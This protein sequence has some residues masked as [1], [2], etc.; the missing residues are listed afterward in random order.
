[1]IIKRHFGILTLGLVLFSLIITI[2]NLDAEFSLFGGF[3]PSAGK[4]PILAKVIYSVGVFFLLSIPSVV[5]FGFF[6]IF[7]TT[8][9][10]F[11][12]W[13]TFWILGWLGYCI[14]FYYSI[15]IWFEFDISQIIK[16]QGLFVF[17][18]NIFLFFIWFLN[19]I[20]S[21]CL[22]KSKLFVIISWL[23]TTVFIA[24]VFVS[25]IVFNLGN[26]SF[27]VLSIAWLISLAFLISFLYRV[28]F[29]NLSNK[30]SN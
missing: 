28:F 2:F 1:M 6:N 17:S 22:K 18:M 15:F 5:L 30:T 20:M 25:S 7:R 10:I 4:N 14:H 21:L 23:T 29:S 19:I 16:R 13:Q 27:F 11:F 3:I 24:S 26:R 12:I 8:E 9:K